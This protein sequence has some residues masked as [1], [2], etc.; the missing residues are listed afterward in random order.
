MVRSPYRRE[1]EFGLLV[2]GIIAFLGGWWIF[3][4]KFHAIR[5]WF[6]VVGGLGMILALLAPRALVLPRR[7]WM[8]F[9]EGLSYVMTTIILAIV[10]FLVVTPIGFFKRLFGWDPL[11]RRSPGENSYWKPYPVRQKDPKHYEKLY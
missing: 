5:N 7:G 6:V 8:M 9:A 11:R 3:R 1:H 2:G 10:F 4:E